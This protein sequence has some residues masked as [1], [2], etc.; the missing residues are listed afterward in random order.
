MEGFANAIDELH[1]KINKAMHYQKME[2]AL[3]GRGT[4]LALIAKKTGLGSSG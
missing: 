3:S 2:P 1:A 4:Q